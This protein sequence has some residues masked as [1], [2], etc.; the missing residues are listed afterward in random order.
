MLLTAR[1]GDAGECVPRDDLL[2]CSDGLGRFSQDRP[3]LFRLVDLPSPLTSD[4]RILV[5]PRDASTVADSL[6]QVAGVGVETSSTRTQAAGGSGIAAFDRQLGTT[7]QAA[8]ED[9]QPEV[10]ITLPQV[11][12]LRGIRLVNRQGVNASSPLELQVQAGDRTFQGFTDTRGLFRFDPV[13]TDTV[14]VR[15]LSANQIRSRSELGELSL[16]V[17]VSE[18]GLIGADDLRR[19]VPADAVIDLPC[20]TGPDILVDGEVTAREHRSLPAPNSS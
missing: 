17:G 1:P 12:E 15:F 3:G 14:T 13:T 8:P 20:G 7:W 2:L 19:P 5:A 18:I 4:P 10:T 6:A 11:R 9:P 16:P